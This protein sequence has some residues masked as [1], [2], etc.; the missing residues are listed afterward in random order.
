MLIN[1][2]HSQYV[3]IVVT[4]WVALMRLRV[5]ADRKRLLLQWYCLS[6][7]LVFSVHDNDHT[8]QSDWYWLI[9]L[10]FVFPSSRLSERV[11]IFVLP[12]GKCKIYY[13]SVLGERGSQINWIW[14]RTT[15]FPLCEVVT[16]S[17]Y[18]IFEAFIWFGTKGWIGILFLA[19]GQKGENLGATGGGA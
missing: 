11:C 6:I 12:A 19:P 15:H 7:L 16:Y 2:T 4:T 14:E 5:R 9:V 3:R 1:V 17:C 13:D 18:R 8:Y 10:H